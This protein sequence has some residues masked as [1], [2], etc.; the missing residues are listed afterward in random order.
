M[1]TDGCALDGVSVATGCEVG[2]RSMRVLDFGLIAATFVDTQ[3][4]QAVRI[5][6]AS[7]VRQAVSRYAGDAQDAWHAYLEAYQVMPSEELLEAQP[8]RLLVSLA[9][10]LS[11]EDA[12]ASCEA[13]GE[14]IFNQREVLV[15]GRVLCKACAGEAYVVPLGKPNRD[16]ASLQEVRVPCE[17]A[18]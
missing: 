10:I 17:M 9:L 16:S 15:G 13:C 2:R 3:N 1:E 7:H 5:R 12:K 11:H 4:G 14:E 6:P 18:P 8:V